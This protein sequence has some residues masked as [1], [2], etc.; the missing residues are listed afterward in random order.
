MVG[1]NNQCDVESHEEVDKN[2]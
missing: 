1:K 2:N